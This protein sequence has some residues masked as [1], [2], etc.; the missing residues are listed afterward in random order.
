MYILS[1]LYICINILGSH[2]GRDDPWDCCK[3]HVA[4]QLWLKASRPKPWLCKKGESGRPLPQDPH[5]GSR[6]LGDPTPFT[7]LLC[8]F[9]LCHSFLVLARLFL[10]NWSSEKLLCPQIRETV[11]QVEFCTTL[12]DGI[13]PSFTFPG[14]P[15]KTWEA[16]GYEPK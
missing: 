4:R 2:P 3:S 8:P 11:E 14:Q 16:T 15:S 10:A 6:C 9:F 5:T 7:L 1:P 12:L 13:P